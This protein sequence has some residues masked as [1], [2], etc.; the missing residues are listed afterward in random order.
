MKNPK[1]TLNTQRLYTWIM[2]IVI[3]VVLLWGLSSIWRYGSSKKA[4]IDE[5]MLDLNAKVEDSSQEDFAFHSEEITVKPVEKAKIVVENKE[6]VTEKEVI[7]EKKVITEKEIPSVSTVSGNDVV[8]RF[9]FTENDALTWPIEGGILLNY[10]MDRTIW[11]PTLKEYKCNSGLVI[12]AAVDDEIHCAASGVVESIEYTKEYG[13]VITVD[14]GN[15][16]KTVYGQVNNSKN[17]KEGSTCI[18]GE[19]IGTINP[20]SAYY[21]VEGDNLFFKV[22]KDGTPVNPLNF[23]EIE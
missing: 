10:S 9:I 21:S 1:N 11:F 5:R 15:G 13:T 23:L 19:V 14:I 6:I 7:T 2:A 20:T 17:L 12:S 3:A 4:A 22:T 16:Y 8:S 18:E